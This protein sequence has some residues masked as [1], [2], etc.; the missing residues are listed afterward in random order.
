MFR[1]LTIIREPALNMA[2]VIFMLKHFSIQFPPISEKALLFGRSPGF[3]RLSFWQ[4]QQLN[5]D[6]YG[7]LM[8]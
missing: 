1:S 8:K 5:E 3:A 7:A 6:G 2:K 4:D